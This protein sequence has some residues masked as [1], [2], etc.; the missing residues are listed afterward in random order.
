MAVELLD[1]APAFAESMTQCAHAL[2]AFT[3]WNLTDVLRGRPDAPALDTVDV[4]QP[5]LW[6]VMVSLARL[7]QSHGVHPDAVVGHSQGEIAAAVIAGALTLEDGAR[8]VALRSQLIAEELAGPGGMLSITLPATQTRQRIEPWGN[9][10]SLA[11]INS[12]RSTVVC[13]HTTA[14][15]ELQTTLEND[16]IRTRRIPVDYASHSAFVETIK[17]RLLQALTPLQPRTAEIPLYSTVTG[18]LLDTT[19]M[20]AEYWYTN[21]RNTVLFEDATRALLTTGHNLFIETSPHP[22]LKTGLEETITTTHTN[23]TT[24]GSLHRQ[25]GTLTRFTTSLA[26][27][28]VHGAPVD[29]SPLLTNR[30][31]THTDLPTYAFQRQRYWL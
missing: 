24:I 29:W 8:T 5:A 10:L 6:A 25:E 15:D 23:A 14:L 9:K 12:P 13:G 19:T 16:H 3:D 30:P 27:A 11:A 31:G 26:Q 28:Y 2:Q 7:W 17:D 4:I 1:S 22:V 18:D 20:N 21:L